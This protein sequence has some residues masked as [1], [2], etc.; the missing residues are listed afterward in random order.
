MIILTGSDTFVVNLSGASSVDCFVSYLDTTTSSEAVQGLRTAQVVSIAGNTTLV[1]APA[2]GVE[3]VVKY[4]CLRAATGNTVSVLVGGI[5]VFSACTLSANESLVYTDTEGWRVH[6]GQGRVK[7]L[8]IAAAT[9]GDGG[10]GII[11]GAGTVTTGNVVFSNSNGVTFGMA[12]STVT[13]SV[14]GGGGADSQIGVVSHIGGNSVTNVTRLAYSNASNVTWSLST[15]ANAATVLASVAAG[16]GGGGF[17]ASAAGNSQST[18]TVVWSNSNNVSFGMAGG[19]ITATATFAAPADSILGR[20][21]HIGG[22]SVTNVTQLAFSNASN[23]TFSL[24]TAAGGAT[25]LG[26]VAPP[27]AANLALSAGTVSQNIGTLVFSNSNGVSFGMNGSTI[28]AS[29]AGGGGADGGVFLSA[30]TTSISSGQVILSNSNGVSFGLNGSTVTASAPGIGI[31]ELSQLG[32]SSVGSV[33]SLHLASLN[34]LFVQILTTSPNAAT[35]SVGAALPRMAAGTTTLTQNNSSVT[36]VFS[37]S[38]NVSFGLNAFTFTASANPDIGSIQVAGTTGSNVTNLIFTNQNN[39]TW[40]ATTAAGVMTVGASV[41]AAGGG[42]ANAL[43]L[44]GLGGNANANSNIALNSLQN[45]LLFFR[46]FQGELFGTAAA[47]SPVFALTGGTYNTTA[48]TVNQGSQLAL[49]IRFGMYTLPNATQASLYASGSFTASAATGSALS[50]LFHGDRLVLGNF[51]GSSCP[52][53]G[54]GAVFAYNIS[55]AA[56]NT[57]ISLRA[58]SNFGAIFTGFGAL[59][60][61]STTNRKH[62]IWMGAYSAT[63]GAMPGSVALSQLVT[64]SNGRLMPVFSLQPVATATLPSA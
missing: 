56:S 11:A 63:T 61:A 33:S 23:V 13:A 57:S 41:A 27:G 8:T 45:S 3:R 4:V 44:G 59:G 36:W 51:G 14:A 47:F 1:S 53:A 6:D 49:T 25:L 10:V 26:S 9:T 55:L 35:W 52:G 7:T 40:Q 15:A 58:D 24:S 62:A 43:P 17:A 39:V 50:N 64:N 21:S 18:G 28:T 38:N 12:G 31:A 20:V 34:N 60:A 29:A 22:N 2:A 32:G 16:G 54:S 19:T 48:S 37:N 30:G 5:N 42:G 46:P